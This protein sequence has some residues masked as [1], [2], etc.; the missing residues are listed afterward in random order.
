LGRGDQDA[1]CNTS[2]SRQAS[3]ARDPH[4][5]GHD[6]HASSGQAGGSCE[7]GARPEEARTGRQAE[8]CAQ[9]QASGEEGCQ[10]EDE[11]ET[12]GQEGCE[13]DRQALQ[14]G[15]LKKKIAPEPGQDPDPAFR[16]ALNPSAG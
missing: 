15:A 8:G 3:H 16:N 1:G 6:G 2:S 5:H 14:P 4:D 13:E 9:G 10:E 11:G 7:A 12:A